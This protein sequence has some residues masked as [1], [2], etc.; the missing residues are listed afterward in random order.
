MKMTKIN[1]KRAGIAAVAAAALMAGTAYQANALSLLDLT[2]GLSAGV[3]ALPSFKP[4]CAT[5]GNPLI[6]GGE[7]SKCVAVT[8]P[9]PVVAKVG[10]K[11]GALPVVAIVPAGTLTQCP[12]INLRLNITAVA[13]DALVE[14][15][16]G[17]STLLSKSIQ[18]GALG[19]FVALCQ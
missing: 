7:T 9:I 18:T 11:V 10:V 4:L 12:S 14:V 15:T 19:D 3:T 6:L 8:S 16:V 5:T 13:A 1:K 2:I 17:G